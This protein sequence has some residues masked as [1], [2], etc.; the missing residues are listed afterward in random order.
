MPNGRRI[1][2]RMVF[3][4]GRNVGEE[5]LALSEMLVK[6]ALAIGSWESASQSRFRR[7]CVEFENPK[8]P[9]YLYG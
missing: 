3:S 1:G 6:S 7:K 8:G 5:G 9:K 4:L 2:L